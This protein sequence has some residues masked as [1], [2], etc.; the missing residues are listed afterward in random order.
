MIITKK[1]GFPCCSERAETGLLKKAR[2]VQ[3]LN[4]IN[5][6]KWQGVMDEN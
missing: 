2:I 3:K 4:Q 5:W 6:Y 1:I